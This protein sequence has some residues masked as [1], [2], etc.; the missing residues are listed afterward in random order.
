MAIAALFLLTSQQKEKKIS[1]SDKKKIEF[2]TE[3]E[4][5][6]KEYYDK[7]QQG[8]IPKNRPVCYIEGVLE[9]VCLAKE[10]VAKDLS[11]CSEDIY[12]FVCVPVYHHLWPESTIQNKDY[13]VEQEIAKYTETRLLA[14]L[15]DNRFSDEK[16]A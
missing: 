1:A 6:S 13:L 10:L 7:K 4:R 12:D 9:S 5:L 3:I 14:E 11:F 16:F 8:P 2:N 15:A